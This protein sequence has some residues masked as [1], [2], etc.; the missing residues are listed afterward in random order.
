M[1]RKLVLLAVLCSPAWL[2]AQ[3][4][5]LVS[6]NAANAP[7]NSTHIR[8]F[9]FDSSNNW[10]LVDRNNTNACISTN[11]GST[12]SSCGTTG[13]VGN[14]WSIKW[15][16]KHSQIILGMTASGGTVHY[17]RSSNQC[18][19]WTAITMPWNLDSIPMQSGG[20]AIDATGGNIVAGGFNA[21]FPHIGIWYSTD[22]GATTHEA[23]F[24]ALPGGSGLWSAAQNT[25]TG[26]IGA[27]LEQYCLGESSDGGLTFVEVFGPDSDVTGILTDPHCGDLNGIT[28]DAAGNWLAAGQYGVWKSSGTPGGKSYSWTPVI[29]TG[30]T[31]A[32]RS[33]GRD[34]LGVLYWGHSNN[35]N[36]PAQWQP[37]VFRS[38]DQGNSWSAFNSGL[39]NYEAW[40][41]KYNSVD[42]YEYIVLQNGTGNLGYIYRVQIVAPTATPPT[43]AVG[44]MAKLQ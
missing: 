32:S 41:F 14:G 36:T 9:D 43:P 30:G 11:Q 19:T 23:T 37:A 7:C 8:D 20:P 28:N 34:A 2:S 33:M 38:T 31:V 21:P 17:Y 27:G 15:D 16:A 42:G 6:A 10:Y 39:P 24:S 29:A 40:S 12:W 35:A 25:I 3:T 5:S 4:W 22:S 18:S 13:I 26:N 44:M 1:V